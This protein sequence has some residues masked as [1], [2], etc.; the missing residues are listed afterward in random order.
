MANIQPMT[1]D[2]RELR[3]EIHSAQTALSN[4][5]TRLRPFEIVTE[6]GEIFPVCPYCG[7]SALSHIEETSQYRSGV[8]TIT[9][10]GDFLRI[11]NGTE[12]V[13]A[14]GWDGR[15]CCDDCDG[16]SRLPDDMGISWF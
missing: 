7:C 4:A 10:G 12:D 9:D 2:D 11:H 16:W 1:A 6:D 15:F 3:K 13:D 5:Y 8:E 14:D